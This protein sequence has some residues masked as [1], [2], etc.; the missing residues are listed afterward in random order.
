[1]PGY[2][3]IYVAAWSETYRAAAAGDRDALS[4]LAGVIAHERI[5][6]SNGLDEGPAYEAEIAMLRRCG[7]SPALIDGVRRAMRAVS[8]A[9][10][11][12]SSA[13]SFRGVRR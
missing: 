1:M 10:Q 12:T 5:H 2:P 4:K 9:K 11:P 13:A 7:A 3:V 6:V 8:Q